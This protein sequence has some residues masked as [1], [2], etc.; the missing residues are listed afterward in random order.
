M[1][2]PTNPVKFRD[3][4]L[5]SLARKAWGEEW[6]KPDIGYEFSNGRKFDNTDRRGGGPYGTSTP[7]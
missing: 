3:Y 6:N 4:D 5:A 1:T 2:T 7:A